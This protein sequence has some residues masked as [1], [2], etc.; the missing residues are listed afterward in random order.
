M[1]IY[2]L[3]ADLE[4]KCYEQMV[5]KEDNKKTKV[6]ENGTLITQFVEEMRHNVN[7]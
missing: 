4:L 1:N 6:K 7:S 2:M 5:T 3:V